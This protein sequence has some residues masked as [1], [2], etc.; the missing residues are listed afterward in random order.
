M[1]FITHTSSIN[2]IVVVFFY[3]FPLPTRHP[4]NTFFGADGKG[5]PSTILLRDLNLRRWVGSFT[6]LDRPS[7]NTGAK[8]LEISFFFLP[9]FVCIP[10]KCG[11]LVFSNKY[12]TRKFHVVFV[13]Y[14]RHNQFYGTKPDFSG[15]VPNKI[16]KEW[17]YVS[18]ILG[19][20]NST[21]TRLNDKSPRD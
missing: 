9:V 3:I 20:W 16:K 2:R 18:R 10:H 1:L 15:S 8:D 13:V 5:A 4:H 17:E 19:W 7:P 11:L 6:Q 12:L 21:K 14:N